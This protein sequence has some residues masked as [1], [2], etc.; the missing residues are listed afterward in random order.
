MHASIHNALLAQ[1]VDSLATL[2]PA[3]SAAW[4]PNKDLIESTSSAASG[5]L[6]SD[7]A[8]R[9]QRSHLHRDHHHQHRARVDR[10]RPD[11]EERSSFRTCASSR[12][13]SK[14]NPSSAR[15]DYPPA[16]AC[17]VAR[18]FT[19]EVATTSALA[20]RRIPFCWLAAAL[21]WAWSSCAAG[22]QGATVYACRAIGTGA[23]RTASAGA[24][25]RGLLRLYAG[26]RPRA[27]R[28]R[29]A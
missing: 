21:S 16:T 17:A 6:Q 22:A 13:Q 1:V 2:F 7:A 15:I 20:D 28:T 24:L 12:A 11:G 14:S 19:Y 4:G 23:A 3:T 29:A 5:H 27:R 10:D 25:D 26:A 9:L 8:A 18:E